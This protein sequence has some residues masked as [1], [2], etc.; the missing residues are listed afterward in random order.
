ML[1]KI[2]IDYF[3]AFFKS[4]FLKINQFLFFLFFLFALALH[5]CVQTFSSCG[6]WGLLCLVVRG[7]LI[8]A[9]FL[10]AEHG[11]LS[12]WASVVVAHRLSCSKAC[13]FFPD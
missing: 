11:L 2:K 10:L 6:K 7:L 5:C 3:N 13:G 4:M 9:A 8:L 12:V 1:P